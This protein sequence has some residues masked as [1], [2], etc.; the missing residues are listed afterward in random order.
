[1]TLVRFD[2]AAA[3]RASALRRAA[4]AV[5]GSGVTDCRKGWPVGAPPPQPRAWRYA[6]DGS[7]G[8][9][10]RPSSSARPVVSSPRRINHTAH[11]AYSR[12]C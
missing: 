4:A 9:Q 12:D 10:T 8:A 7:H 1:M 3:S 5:W 11:M 2:A 6:A